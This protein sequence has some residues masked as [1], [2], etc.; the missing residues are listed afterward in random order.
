MPE[1]YARVQWCVKM[2]GNQSL[3]NWYRHKGRLYFKT[4]DMLE[5]YILKWE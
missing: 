1:S 4:R 5:L 2:F 3:N